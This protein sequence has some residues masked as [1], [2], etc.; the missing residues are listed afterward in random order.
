MR[1]SLAGANGQRG[2]KEQHA[3]ASPTFEIAM[4]WDGDAEVVV[5]FGVYVPQRGRDAHTS[6]DREGEA[7]RLAGT[8]VRVL[9]QD[10]HFGVAVLRQV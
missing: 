4:V 9:A 6:A 10:H 2:V 5:Q 7:V 8:V 1:G 3:L